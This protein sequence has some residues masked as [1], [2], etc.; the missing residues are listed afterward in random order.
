MRTVKNPRNPVINARAYPIR[1]DLVASKFQAAHEQ[2]A[3][4]L[5]AQLAE[6]PETTEAIWF[7]Q[8]ISNQPGGVEGFV[9]RLVQQ[10]SH[11]FT[12]GAMRSPKGRQ[13]TTVATAV[14]RLSSLP[15]SAIGRLRLSN[16]ALIEIGVEDDDRYVE[17]EPNGR[18]IQMAPKVEAEIIRAADPKNLQQLCQQTALEELPTLLCEVC[19]QA[20]RP[21]PEHT[22]NQTDLSAW[23]VDDVLALIS[24]GMRHHTMQVMDSIA[25]T[26]V[27]KIIFDELEHAA[28]DRQPVFIVGPSRIGKTVALGAWTSMHPGLGRL[29]TVPDCNR[30][31]DFLEAHADALGVSHNPGTSMADLRANVKY[32][33]RWA[34]LLV[35]YD[36]GHYL[37]PTRYSKGTPPSR[38]N[39]IRGQIIDRGNGCAVFATPQAYDR[40]FDAY[41]KKTQYTFEQWVGR[42]GKP[43]PLPRRLVNE[44]LLAVVRK[45]CPS[46]DD[47]LVVLVAACASVS[48]E[49]L[50]LIGKIYSWALHFAKKAERSTPC[51][52]DI[53]KAL[54]RITRK[55]LTEMLSGSEDA[56]D[57]VRPAH[58]STERSRGVADNLRIAPAPAPRRRSQTAA[59]LVPQD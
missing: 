9:R 8:W 32:V 59:E 28:R 10:F 13:D 43:L 24:D 19:Q 31:R 48:D 4:D 30:E 29:V 16:Q 53:D 51:E 33:M 47:H 18:I 40:A 27:T 1:S 37:L 17:H 6:R 22:L 7:L 14:G 57:S 38:L 23:Y 45:L 3:P 25:H 20:W 41:V 12:T 49:Y 56:Q 54:K 15:R 58:R 21:F 35:V 26:E 46:L 42:I 50:S 11:R 52:T 36:E 5:A 55:G 2:R 34:R 39:W 44:E